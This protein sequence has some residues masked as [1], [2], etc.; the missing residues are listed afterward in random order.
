MARIEHAALW[1]TDL[2]RSLSFYET[3]F[4]G[5][6]GER[7]HNSEKKFTS[8]FLEFESGARLEL[9]HHPDLVSIQHELEYVTG[10]AHLAISVGSESAVNKLTRRLQNDGYRVVGEPRRTGDGYFESVVLDPDGNRVEI[11]V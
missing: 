6:P 2:E 8:Y 9:M 10:Y 4:G 3:Y 11:T 7:Y 1:T 5:V